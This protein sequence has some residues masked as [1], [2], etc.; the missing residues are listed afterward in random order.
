MLQGCRKEGG[1]GSDSTYVDRML[2]G[3]RLDT[4]NAVLGDESSLS[5]MVALG[6]KIM[7][8]EE[9]ACFGAENCSQ[10]SRKY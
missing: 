4:G 6:D 8:K 3:W 10:R 7:W 9:G 2:H 1:S 5:S